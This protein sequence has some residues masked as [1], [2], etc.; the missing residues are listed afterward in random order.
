VNPELLGDGEWVAQSDQGI[1]L[2]LIGYGTVEMKDPRKVV[3]EI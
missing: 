3:H 1:E 2:R